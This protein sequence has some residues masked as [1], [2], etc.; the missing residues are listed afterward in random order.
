MGRRA[1]LTQLAARLSDPA[2]RRVTLVGPGGVGK[3]R[4]ALQAAAEQVSENPDGVWLVP[5]VALSPSALLTAA[6][7]QALQLPLRGS[8]DPAAQL[9]AFLQRRKLLVLDNFEHLLDDRGRA[10]LLDLL[11]HTLAVQV[12]VTSRE[13]LHISA[14]PFPGASQVATACG[15]ARVSAA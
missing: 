15:A 4:L 11:T 14:G 9:L 7:A 3:T 13:R 2:C 10:W 8:S 6:V 12:L 5:L 1:E